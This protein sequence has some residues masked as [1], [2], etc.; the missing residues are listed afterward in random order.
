LEAHILDAIAMVNSHGMEPWTDLSI[1]GFTAG[2]EHMAL[3]ID[4]FQRQ[5]PNNQKA[6]VYGAEL[7]KVVGQAGAI[8]QDAAAKQ[9]SEIDENDPDVQL[10]RAKTQ[11]IYHQMEIMGRKFGVDM[12]KER[13][14]EQQ[15]QRRDEG[16]DQQRQIM[17]RSQLAN[18]IQ[19]DREFQLKLKEMQKPQPTTK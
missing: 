1:A 19:Q 3:H 6:K 14:L 8:I 10:K 12:E 16:S 13:L 15:R 18:E 11:Q 5:Q 4:E 7:Q 17:Q 2:V 9:E